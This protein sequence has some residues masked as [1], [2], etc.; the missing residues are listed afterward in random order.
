MEERPITTPAAT[1]TR[2]CEHQPVASETQVRVPEQ[3]ATLVAALEHASSS[4]RCVIIISGL[5]KE[6]TPVSISSHFVEL[7]AT[8][9]AGAER[10]R[11]TWASDGLILSGDGQAVVRGLELCVVGPQ[12]DAAV[13]RLSGSSSATLQDCKLTCHSN[14]SDASPYPR[15]GAACILVSRGARACLVDCQL[16]A[17]SALAR[18][19]VCRSRGSLEAERCAFESCGSSACWCDGAGAT[20]ELRECSIAVCGGY[21]ALY[22]SNGGRLALLGVQQQRNAHGY[23]MM[24]LHERSRINAVG[25][26]F[27]HNLWAGVG[28][29]WSGAAHVEKCEICGNGGPGFQVRGSCTAAVTRAGNRESGND[30]D[31]RFAGVYCSDPAKTAVTER[32]VPSR[33]VTVGSVERALR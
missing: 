23:G 9:S 22:A 1:E 21:G 16:S 5:V 4:C 13:V 32:G 15:Q 12:R 19:V 18:G 33:G 6:P 7:R 29:R 28:V 10:P 11:V 25:C 31:V 27:N 30:A 17:P 26:T 14:G 20:A 2:L 8:E 3:A 24:V